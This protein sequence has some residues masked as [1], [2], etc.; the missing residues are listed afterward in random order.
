MNKTISLA[1]CICAFWLF[2]SA[3]F[4]IGN[5]RNADFAARLFFEQCIAFHANPTSINADNDFHLAPLAASKA[6]PFLNN[7]TGKAWEAL[8]TFGN[9][10][11]TIHDNGLCSVHIR[12]V[13]SI[14]IK[15]AFLW[16]LNYIAGKSGEVT[17]TDDKQLKFK[18][19]LLHQYSYQVFGE[20]FGAYIATLHSTTNNTE[21]FQAVMSIA[22][23]PDAL[24]TR[25][26]TE[27][28]MQRFLQICMNTLTA[29]Q[30]IRDIAERNGFR[31]LLPP[32]AA[33]FLSGA[34]GEV[35]AEQNKLGNYAIAIHTDGI[36]TLFVRKIDAGKLET[37]FR[38][39]MPPKDSGFIWI[40]N[41]QTQDTLG[42]KTTGYNIMKNNFLFAT[43]VLSTSV[44]EN[45]NFQGAISMKK[46]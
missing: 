1:S 33:M 39:W 8:G 15:E 19:G 22:P 42:L 29:P 12:H 18:Y 7:Q 11:L 21:Q 35:W 32:A 27:H 45:A 31:R 38:S 2:Q 13:D 36:C 20:K 14:A 3:A 23:L 6:K 46:Y 34:D 40:E 9:F 44:N 26:Q 16:D 25:R 37:A 4:A 10:V 17:Q 5:D 28:A 41:P 30:M 24:F 43:W